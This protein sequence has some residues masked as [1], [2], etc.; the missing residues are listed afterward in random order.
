MTLCLVYK[1]KCSDQSSDTIRDAIKYKLSTCSL[2]WET[3]DICTKTRTICLNQTRQANVLSPHLSRQQTKAYGRCQ[4]VN[5]HLYTVSSVDKI[6]AVIVILYLLLT[7]RDATL[8]FSVIKCQPLAAEC[9]WGGAYGEKMTIRRLFCR[10]VYANDCVQVMS[11]CPSDLKWAIFGAW[12]NKCLVYNEED[13]LRYETCR[14][15]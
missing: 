9:Q 13:I 7:W 11:P 6:A 1:T 15:F 2:R 5:M 8:A 4:K 12:L 14:M 10:S 3:S